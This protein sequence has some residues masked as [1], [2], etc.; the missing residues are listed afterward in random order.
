MDKEGER[1]GSVK[2]KKKNEEH[3]K[4]MRESEKKYGESI[5]RRVERRENKFFFHSIFMF[6]LKANMCCVRRSV[7]Q[8]GNVVNR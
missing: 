3:R 5:R 6:T 8:I 4:K 2:A 7:Q 1:K